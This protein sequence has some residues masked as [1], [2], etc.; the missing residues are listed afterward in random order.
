MK[1]IE[2]LG[3]FIGIIVIIIIIIVAVAPAPGF[4]ATATI[5]TAA[6][7]ADHSAASIKAALTEAVTSA[8]RGAVAM[9]LHHVHLNAAQVVRDAV[10]IQ[11]VATDEEPDQGS[12]AEDPG[13]SADDPTPPASDQNQPEGRS[14]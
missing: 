2:P 4:T 12:S 5:E 8:V 7:L 13:P 1:A 9:G 10:V 11:L 6:S 14:L 3:P